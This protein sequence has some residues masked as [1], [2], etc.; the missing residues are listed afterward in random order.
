MSTPG[1]WVVEAP[2]VNSDVLYAVNADDFRG[3]VACGVFDAEDARLI[4]AAPELLAAL[5]G[6]VSAAEDGQLWSAI[7]EA[8]AAIAKAGQA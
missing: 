1:P 3:E 4:A 6:L 7:D 8:R 2:P 5:R